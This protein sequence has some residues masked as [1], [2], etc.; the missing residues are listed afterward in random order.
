[1]CG[2]G[3]VSFY[4]SQNDWTEYSFFSE[5]KTGREAETEW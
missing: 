4:W 2:L 3:H 5:L 1:M